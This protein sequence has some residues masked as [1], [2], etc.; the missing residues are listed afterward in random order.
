MSSTDIILAHCFIHNPVCVY[1]VL[2]PCITLYVH[3]T[4]KTQQFD[5]HKDPSHCSTFSHPTPVPN[6]WQLL[7]CC[8]FKN[9]TYREWMV[10]NILG[11][12]SF[13]QHNGPRNL[14][15]SLQISV[16]CSLFLLSSILW[17]EFTTQVASLVKMLKLSGEECRYHLALRLIVMRR[18]WRVV[19]SVWN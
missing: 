11:S 8:H 14:L 3:T 2:Y 7:T 13:T 19:V 4:V 1:L 12:T 15:K 5:H 6:P 17:H 9:I 10:C 16:V 18:R